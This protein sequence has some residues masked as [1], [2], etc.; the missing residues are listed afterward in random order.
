[1]LLWG[2]AALLPG[3]LPEPALLGG[4]K[5]PLSDSRGGGGSGPK[6]ERSLD[7]TGGCLCNLD[8]A[9]NDGWEGCGSAE[10]LNRGGGPFEGACEEGMLSSRESENIED[11]LLVAILFSPSSYSTSPSQS[12]RDSQC[13][14]IFWG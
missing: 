6:G 11:N 1:V 12:A 10:A 2:L 3:R 14:E 5:V 9:G 7:G 4:R 13:V 8:E